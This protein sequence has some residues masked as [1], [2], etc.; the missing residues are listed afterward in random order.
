M[1]LQTGMRWQVQRGRLRWNCRA[2]SGARR[3]EVRPACRLLCL[4]G[5]LGVS[6]NRNPD[7]CH[8]LLMPATSAHDGDFARIQN[9][10][11]S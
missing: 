11:T 9:K 8:G 2:V 3:V 4:V 10:E 7:L 1:S 6:K 5:L